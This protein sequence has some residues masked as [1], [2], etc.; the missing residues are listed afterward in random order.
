MAS[1]TLSGLFK[2]GQFVSADMF[3]ANVVFEQTDSGAPTDAYADAAA[4]L[5]VQNIRF[6]GGQADL[7]PQ[8]ANAAGATPVDGVSAINIVDMNG[9]ALRTELVTFL[10]WCRAENEA[11]NPVRTTLII[12]TKHLDTAAYVDFAPK[13]ENFVTKVMQEYG[14]L[15]AAFQI[16]NEHWEMGE[17]AYGTKASLALEAAARGMTTAGVE[18]ADQPDLLIQMATAGN[19][20]S[21]F[22]ATPGVAD[23]IARNTAANKQIIEQLSDTALSVIDGVTEHYYYNKSDYAFGTLDTEVKNIDKDYAIWADTLGKD[24]DLHI[25]EW[26]VK[27]AAAAQHGMVAGSS[28]VKQFENMIQLGVDGA[29]IW[30]FD[31]H[32]RTALTLDTDE[33]VRLDDAGRLLNSAHGAVFDLMADALVGKELVS[34]SF[35]N[36]VPGISVSSYASQE[37]LVLYVSS[38]VLEKTSVTF[39]LASKLGDIG[40]VTAVKIA[41]DTGT[42]NGLQWERGVAANSIEI[43]GEAYFYNEHDADVILTDLVFTDARDIT[44]DLK[45]FEVVELTVSLA[46]LSVP[47]DPQPS[48][49]TPIAPEGPSVP[50]KH[51]FLGGA[52]DDIIQLTESVVYIDGGAGVDKL[53]VD[54]LSSDVSIEFDSFG[55][56][57]L[58][59]APGYANAI[60]L[61][62]LERVEFFDATLALDIDGNSGQ[63]YRLY[64]A[65]FDRTPD[66]EGLEYWIQELDA[67]ISSL[68][69]VAKS[70]LASAEFKANYGEITKLADADF[71]ELL[72]QNV[73]GRLPDEEGYAYWLNEAQNGAAREQIL[74][75]FSES[76]ENKANVAPLI[77]DGIWLF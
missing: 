46:P 14:D 60:T 5:G 2:S 55:K 30:A 59:N 63:A 74:A 10:E 26:N 29:H 44:L 43:D 33:G 6:G 35:S 22:P 23:F 73:L 51:Y 8:K 19:A 56:P 64:Q 42:A 53:I 58:Q 54:A 50:D 1:M 67:G 28:L 34:T 61:S 65:S 57:V 36:G 25:T 45:P 41:Q 52:E 75:S 77:D 3:G 49:Q 38:R 39:D 68:T 13:I 4:A 47:T 40:P 66:Q 16:G 48:G 12:P 76:T 9:D 71:V 7:D 20:G 15:I 17:T 11:G 32:S 24:I 21:E 69:Q 37:E 62:N 72:Y 70:F 18:P 31:Y 27:T